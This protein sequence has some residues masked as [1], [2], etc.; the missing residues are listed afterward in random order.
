MTRWQRMKAKARAEGAMAV[1]DAG[2]IQAWAN[3]GSPHKWAAGDPAVAAMFR[4]AAEIMTADASK[5]AGID[6]VEMIRTTCG[7]VNVTSL[8]G[9]E[10]K[11]AAA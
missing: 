2:A 11:K 5:P 10:M 3:M 9:P 8:P 6:V 7:H 1:I 4:K